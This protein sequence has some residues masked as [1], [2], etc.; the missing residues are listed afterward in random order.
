M[1]HPQAFFSSESLLAELHRLPQPLKYWVGF[2]GGADSTALLQ[3]LHERQ[4]DLTAPLEALHFHHGLQGEGDAW[5]EH[6][7]RF[8]AQRGIAFS[9]KRLEIHAARGVSPEEEARDRRYEAVAKVLGEHEMYLTAHHA[10][11]Q[12]ETLFLNLM[13]GSGIDGLAGI[14]T[15][16]ALDAGWVARPLLGVYRRELLGYLESRGV[17]WVTDPSN[18]D[19]RFD[20]NFLRQEIFPLLESRWPGIAARLARTARNARI[21]A[22]AV[23]AFVDQQAGHLLADSERLPLPPLRS[24]SPDMRSLVLRQW[25]RR[26]ELRA[27]PEN[28]LNEFLEQACAET[29]ASQAEVTWSGWMIKRY[30]QNLWLQRSKALPA[31]PTRP[32]SAGTSLELGDELGELRLEGGDI[33]LPGSWSVRARSPA[34][35]LQLHQDRPRRPAKDL[36]QSSGVPPWLRSCVPI[37]CWDGEPSALGDWLISAKLHA[38][39]T[40][41]RQTLRWQPSNPLLARLRQD[42]HEA[43][44]GPS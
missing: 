8:C 12:A 16:R 24:L 37:L 38:W 7:R 13:R 2:S 6:C 30:R 25:L 42:A 1:S 5:L 32:W 3:A 39:L 35:R 44:H 27:L 9:S 41:N 15:L 33:D 43:V 34:D 26:H 18:R 17:D 14:P 11:D 4:A 22:R 29:P 20:R 21:S 28:R 31:C 36:F 19:V 40:E 23:E 10:D